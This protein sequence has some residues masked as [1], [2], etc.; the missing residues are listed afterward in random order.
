MFYYCV[1]K[2]AFFAAN[3]SKPREPNFDCIFF[4]SEDKLLVRK[5]YWLQ[6]NIVFR[7]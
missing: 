4:G 7:V 3:M 5:G 6:E 2:A 1:P